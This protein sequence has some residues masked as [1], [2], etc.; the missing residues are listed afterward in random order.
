MNISAFLVSQA[1]SGTLAGGVDE[2][3]VMMTVSALTN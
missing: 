1:R 3:I 2:Q